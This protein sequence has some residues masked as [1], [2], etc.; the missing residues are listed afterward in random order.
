MIIEHDGTGQ[1]ED[2]YG[3][4]AIVTEPINGSFDCSYGVTKL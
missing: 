2:G 3:S 4:K 1:M